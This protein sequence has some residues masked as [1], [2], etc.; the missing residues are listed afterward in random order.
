[1]PRHQKLAKI[2]RKEFVFPFLEGRWWAAQ[3][4]NRQKHGRQ[5]TALAPPTNFRQIVSPSGVGLRHE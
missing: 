5:P 4:Q 3:A 1:M 2:G